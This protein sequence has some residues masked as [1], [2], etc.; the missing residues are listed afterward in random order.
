[1][2]QIHETDAL[3]LGGVAVGERDR[4]VALLSPELGLVRARVRGVRQIS[5]KLRSAIEDWSRVKA[6][7]VRGKGEWRLT[8]VVLEEQLFPALLASGGLP[9]VTRA[10]RLVARLAKGEGDGAAPHAALLALARFAA[11]PRDPRTLDAAETVC[12]LRVL[13]GLGYLRESPSLEPLAQPGALDEAT[14]EIARGVRDEAILAI[15]EALAAS[16]L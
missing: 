3:I 14:A 8:N 10:A 16:H 9:S 4:V 12:A 1:V 7:L 5:S 15:N 2:H 13:R 6:Y 11:T